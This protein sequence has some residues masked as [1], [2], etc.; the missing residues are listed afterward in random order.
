MRTMIAMWE[1]EMVNGS[2]MLKCSKNLCTAAKVLHPCPPKPLP[3]QIQ[4]LTGTGTAARPW[5]KIKETRWSQHPWGEE[6]TH[7]D[8][9][10]WGAGGSNIHFLHILP[11][12]RALTERSLHVVDYY[13]E[14]D[15][16]RAS[17]EQQWCT[18]W[19]WLKAVGQYQI[20]NINTQKLCLKTP[21]VA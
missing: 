19:P 3:P 14:K 17:S 1:N 8:G 7:N 13:G 5:D 16:S 9:K 18:L 2:N 6:C 4:L 12:H 15:S 10:D 20:K 11:T 21:F